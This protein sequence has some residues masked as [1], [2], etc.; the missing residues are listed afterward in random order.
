MWTRCVLWTLRLL[1]GVP[2]PRVSRQEAAAI[3]AAECQ[4]RGWRCRDPVVIE[5][6]R[7]WL[8]F[9]DGKVVGSPFVVIDQQNGIV[10]RRALLPR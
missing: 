2:A 3:A 8:V 1:L 10:L 5:Q 7:T 4:R 6:L 9:V